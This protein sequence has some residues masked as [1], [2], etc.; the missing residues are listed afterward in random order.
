[1]LKTTTTL[2]TLIELLVVI[3]II[4]ILAAIVTLRST[5]LRRGRISSCSARQLAFCRAYYA[6]SRKRLSES[7]QTPLGPNALL[8]ACREGLPDSGRPLDSAR[9]EPNRIGFSQAGLTELEA[10]NRRQ[11]RE[12]ETE[13]VRVARRYGA[14][15]VG[16]HHIKLAYERLRWR[17]T[18]SRKYLGSVGGCLLGGGLMS[19]ISMIRAW[20]CAV[21]DVLVSLCLVTAGAVMLALQARYE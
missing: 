7:D 19:L 10:R 17:L 5:V 20:Q 13:S 4:A 2:F 16:P 21:P 15:T 8:F 6:F 3:A 18:G 12:L 11:A 9:H 1:M 14:D